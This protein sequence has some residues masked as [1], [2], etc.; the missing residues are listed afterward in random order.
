[1]PTKRANFGIGT[2]VLFRAALFGKCAEPLLCGVGGGNVAKVFDGIGNA[3]PI[4]EIDLPHKGGAPNAHGGF[5]LG[6]ELASE[7]ACL[8]FKFGIR[9]DAIDEAERRRLACAECASRKQQFKSAMPADNSRQ[10]HE[11]DRRQYTEVD[12]RITESGAC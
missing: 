4:V 8:V 1:M 2:L 11:M 12:F 5:G 7:F 6:R 3:A 9:H 10:V